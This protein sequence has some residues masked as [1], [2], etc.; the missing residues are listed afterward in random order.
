MTTTLMRDSIVGD[1]W[2]LGSMASCPP[3]LILSKDTGEP[4][5][6]II[7]GP[8]R[9]AFDDL[10]ELPKATPENENPKYGASLLFPPN[11]DMTLFYNAYYEVCARDF[12]DK[13]DATTQQYLGLKSPFHD[14]GAK[15]NFGGFTPGCT[16][17]NASSKY[18]PPVTDVRHNP[19]VDRSKVYPGVWAIAAVNAYSYN[20][21]TN[22]GVAFGL[23]NIMIIGDDTKFGGGAKANKD[24]FAGVNISAPIARPDVSNMGGQ[25]PAEAPA[26]IPGYTTPPAGAAPS[27]APGGAPT[28]TPPAAAPAQPPAQPA[29][30]SPTDANWDFMN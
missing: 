18:Q 3:Q 29:T 24:Q 17:F 13:Y 16:Y 5:G 9:I 25:P 27:H 21:K 20:M 28:A 7:T 26:G 4:T 23:Q 6:D 30:T 12:A 19:I 2:I 1:D 10:F 11:V 8:V 22:K 15:A 14:Q